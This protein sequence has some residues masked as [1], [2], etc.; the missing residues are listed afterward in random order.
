MILRA[1]PA[2][3]QCVLQASALV[4]VHYS[5]STAGHVVRRAC[6]NGMLEDVQR[7]CPT[8]GSHTQRR[9]PIERPRKELLLGPTPIFPCTVKHAACGNNV[10]EALSLAVS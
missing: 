6:I 5:L 4:P 10:R 3:L 2:L 9:S 1:T 7:L 8:M